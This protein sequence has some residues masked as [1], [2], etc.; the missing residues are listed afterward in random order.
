MYNFTLFIRLFSLYYY[1]TSKQRVQL[2]VVEFNNKLIDDLHRIFAATAVFAGERFKF[3]LF[4]VVYDG[5]NYVEEP[6]KRGFNKPI[7]N[8][9]AKGSTK[10]PNALMTYVIKPFEFSKKKIE[11]LGSKGLLDESIAFI[12]DISRSTRNDIITLDWSFIKNHIIKDY[13]LLVESEIS[14]VFHLWQTVESIPN[15]T[16]YKSFSKTDIN[17]KFYN[18]LVVKLIIGT[19]PGFHIA[20]NKILASKYKNTINSINFLIKRL[21]KNGK[22]FYSKN[23]YSF[24]YRIGYSNRTATLGFR[25]IGNAVK[26]GNMLIVDRFKD[27]TPL[28]SVNNKE[29]ASLKEAGLIRQQNSYSYRIEFTSTDIEPTQIN[30]ILPPEI[31][32]DSCIWCI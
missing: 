13:S 17:L 16:T 15:F 3:K 14:N 27:F 26:T 25:E 6:L 29:K 9:L 32:R 21:S 31:T 30:I 11:L 10:N 2:N 7:L 1:Q 24:L 12:R 4:T 20:Y 19:S 28:F 8:V 18:D 22:F 5:E 23:A